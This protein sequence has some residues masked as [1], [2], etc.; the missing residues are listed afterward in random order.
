MV[1]LGLPAGWWMIG[2]AVVLA[3]I[4]LI[5]TLR[6]DFNKVDGFHFSAT[7]N[8]DNREG[9]FLLVVCGIGAMALFHFGM[10]ALD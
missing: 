3:A 8:D 10:R 4:G 6:F 1:I 9:A 5:V 7:T 2:G